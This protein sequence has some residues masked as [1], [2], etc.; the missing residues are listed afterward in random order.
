MRT[1]D[2]WYDLP[3]RLIA[4]H[5]AGQRD[6]SRL[7][8][9]NRKTGDT[10]HRFFYDLPRYLN[11]GDCLVLNNTRVLPARLLGER[12]GG[13]QAELLL[14]RDLGGG[15]WECLAKPGK[16]IRV[17]DRLRFGGDALAGTVEERGEGGLRT[18]R[19]V[20]EGVFLELLERL[21]RMPLPPYIR[22][23]LDDPGKYQTVY[24]SE[25]GSAAAP[26]A[27]LH[28]TPE[29][30]QR[31]GEAGVSVIEIT[32]HVGLG[33]FRPVQVE[34]VED[35][36]MHSEYFHI[37]AGAAGEINRARQGGGRVVAVGTTVCRTLESA[38]DPAGLIR[39]AAGFTDIFITPGYRFRAIDC[40]L[41]N[42]HLPESTLM[43]LIS[44]FSTREHVLRA[45]QEAVA[46]EYRFFSFGD[47]MLIL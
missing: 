11:P 21:G 22:E 14:L 38:A 3:E 23:R 16:R 40:L 34:N 45:Y 10:D 27:G 8:I 41:T 37:S 42:F 47:A 24:A 20:H 30:L 29:L 43:M 28:F 33:T 13:G 36:V 44:A 46:R 1:N 25:P 35:H 17:G 31:I 6:H 5:P 32:L 2:F 26:T 15:R 18:V 9:L 12:S 4:Q 19:F 7:M 39:E